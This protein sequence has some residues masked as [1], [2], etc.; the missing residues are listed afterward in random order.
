MRKLRHWIKP[1]TSTPR[2]DVVPAPQGRRE[3]KFIY[4]L[5]YCKF[6]TAE[7]ANRLGFE[8]PVSSHDHY[9]N[10]IGTYIRPNVWYRGIELAHIIYA[11]TQEQVQKWL[12]QKYEIH[13]GIYSKASGWGWVLTKTNGMGIKEIKDNVFFDSYEEAL[14]VG[15]VKALQFIKKRR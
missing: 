7:F 3:D 6:P 14:E 8:P 11:P 2:P 15:L 1:P 10:G 4:N 5:E 9:W 13:V 12:R